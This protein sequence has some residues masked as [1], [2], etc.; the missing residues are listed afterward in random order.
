MCFDIVENS[1]FSF[2]MKRKKIA[3]EWSA[4]SGKNSGGKNTVAWVMSQ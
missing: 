4:T 2:I 1:E 3:V